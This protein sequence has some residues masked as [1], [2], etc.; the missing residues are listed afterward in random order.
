LS[1]SRRTITYAWSLCWTGGEQDTH[2]LVADRAPTRLAPDL[3]AL[4][5][6]GR[7]L[8]AG[9]PFAASQLR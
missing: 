3:R 4:D 9:L 1:S 5:A 8:A 2:V 7:P 6:R